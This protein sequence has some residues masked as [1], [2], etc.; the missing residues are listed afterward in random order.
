MINIDSKLLDIHNK[1]DDSNQCGGQQTSDSAHSGPA[2]PCA[3]PSEL[4]LYVSKMICIVM[5]KLMCVYLSF[6]KLNA[7]ESSDAQL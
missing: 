6:K 7:S 1:L 5:I 4:M 2:P 3:C